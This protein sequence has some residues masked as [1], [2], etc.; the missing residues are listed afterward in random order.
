MNIKQNNSHSFFGLGQWQSILAP[1]AILAIW[2]S[3]QQNKVAVT[4]LGLELTICEPRVWQLA[5]AKTRLAQS[6]H[7][8]TLQNFTLLFYHPKNRCWRRCCVTG[9]CSMRQS[10]SNHSNSWGYDRGLFSLATVLWYH[11]AAFR[12][13]EQPQ[14]TLRC[15]RGSETVT[16]SRCT[17]SPIAVQ[18]CVRLRTLDKKRIMCKPTTQNNPQ[19]WLCAF[20]NLLYFLYLFCNNVRSNLWP[21]KTTVATIS[22][23]WCLILDLV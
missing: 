19:S 23:H 16:L 17:N 2:E 7:Y 5:H 21:R 1:G 8:L 11:T 20:Q 3:V 22:R 14:D 18:L 6:H 13:R 4:D 10:H 9:T 12:C 15:C